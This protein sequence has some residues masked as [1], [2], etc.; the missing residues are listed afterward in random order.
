MVPRF[1]SVIFDERVRK[2]LQNLM[3][4]AQE[5][6]SSVSKPPQDLELPSVEPATEAMGTLESVMFLPSPTKTESEVAVSFLIYSIFN[7]VINI[8][9][10]EHF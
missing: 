5:K 8:D 7:L 4:M 1:E 3:N 6:D 10:N 9:Q 2:L